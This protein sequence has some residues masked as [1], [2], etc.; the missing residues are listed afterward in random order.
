MR[1]L[2]ETIAQA[3]R[4]SGRTFV[5][6]QYSPLGGPFDPEVLQTLHSADIPFLLGTSNAMRVLKYLALRRE[7]WARAAGASDAQG[8]GG[9]APAPTVDLACGD[10]LTARRALAL[11]GIPVA[12]AGLARSEEEAVALL[13]RFDAPVAVKAEVAGL[14]HKSDVGC[15]RLGCA[16]E[17]DVAAAYREVV[18]NARKAGFKNAAQALIQPMVKGVAEAYAGI[19]DD[20]LFGPAI[21][22]GLGGIFVEIFKD[23]TT[24]MAPLSHEDAVRMIHRLEAASILT[25]ARGRR[26]GDIEA[27]A[28]LLVRLGQFALAHAGRFR[29]LDLNP[30]IV[31]AAGEGVVAVDIAIE[32]IGDT[33]AIAAHAAS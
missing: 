14:L 10:F 4:A 30:I 24:E 23:A 13:R 17:R 26:A 16:S 20:P 15:V 33:P 28:D 1:R 5:A 25:G 8:G 31:R 27:L 32:P 18:A 7:Y 29:A 3:A 11:F 19:I 12:D 2:A 6:Y 21:C 9:T 22:F